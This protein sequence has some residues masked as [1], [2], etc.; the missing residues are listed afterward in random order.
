MSRKIASAQSAPWAKPSKSDAITSSPI[1]IAV[2]TARPMTE[3][4]RSWSS[5]PA[6]MKRAMWAV[7]KTPSARAKVRARLSKAS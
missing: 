5:A 2:L 7:R 6:S 1:A 4:R 3:R